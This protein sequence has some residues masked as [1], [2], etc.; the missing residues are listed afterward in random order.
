MSCVW[1]NEIRALIEEEDQPVPTEFTEPQNPSSKSLREHNI[2]EQFRNQFLVREDKT[3]YLQWMDHLDK[4][5]KSALEGSCQQLGFQVN[6]AVFSPKGSY[7]AVC[8]H[9]GVQLYYSNSLKHKGLLRHANPIDA[10]FSPDERFL[11]SS[12]GPTSK[13]RENFIIWAVE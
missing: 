3:L 7:L 11:V 2:D 8:C 5:A 13:N 9:E 1:V 10:K 4:S 6:K 12:N